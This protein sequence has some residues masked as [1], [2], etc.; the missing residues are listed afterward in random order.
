MYPMPFTPTPIVAR[1]LAGQARKR[2]HRETQRQL[3]KKNPA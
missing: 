1:R 2:A 3:T